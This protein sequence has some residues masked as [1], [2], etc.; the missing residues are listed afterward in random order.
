MWKE[1]TGNMALGT[2]EIQGQGLSTQMINYVYTV[3]QELR[4]LGRLFFFF[5]VNNS[6][7]ELIIID[8]LLPPWRL[9]HKE[10]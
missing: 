9:K 10:K 1:C 3:S 7:T 2:T 8:S 5:I 4:P 6:N